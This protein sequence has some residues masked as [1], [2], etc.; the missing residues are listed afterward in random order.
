M[1]LYSSSKLGSV[2]D[3]E[4]SGSD[5][6][7]DPEPDSGPDPGSDPGSD[8][9]PDPVS[10]PGPVGSTL[11]P[12]LVA[13]QEQLGPFSC[14]PAPPGNV[15]EPGPVGLDV[16]EGRV[17]LGGLAVGL[18]GLGVVDVAI[19]IVPFTLAFPFLETTSSVYTM[20]DLPVRTTFFAAPE[21]FLSHTALD[22]LLNFVP[23]TSRVRVHVQVVFPILIF[24]FLKI[25]GA[26]R[27][28]SSF[29]SASTST[30]F[31]SDIRKS[32]TH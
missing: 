8:P 7:S 24:S 31:I 2:P 21:H 15:P 4:G 14:S 5:P 16:P 1:P 20:P 18:G 23:S 17:G 27:L 32:G 11:S 25:S 10:E 19:L 22:F 6:V 29:T 13:T 3:P 12:V 26:A 28:A 30:S 9:V